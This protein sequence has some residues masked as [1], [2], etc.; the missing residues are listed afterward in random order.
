MR[1]PAAHNKR[2]RPSATAVPGVRIEVVAMVTTTGIAA[3]DRVA[4]V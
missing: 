2:K 1:P 4:A 3:I